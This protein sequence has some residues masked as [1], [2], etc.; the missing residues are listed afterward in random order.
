MFSQIKK[1]KQ[2]IFPTDN[3][4][5]KITWNTLS[6][7]GIRGGSILVSLLLWEITKRQ[8]TQIIKKIKDLP[9]GDCL[10]VQ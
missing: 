2:F 10:N 4:S 5:K 3:R 6:L 1:I 8:K 9:Y 7:F